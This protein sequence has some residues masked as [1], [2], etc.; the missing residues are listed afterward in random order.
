MRRASRRILL[1]FCVTHSFEMTFMECDGQP[2]GKNIGLAPRRVRMS[3]G[4]ARNAVITK[5]FYVRG[6]AIRRIRDSRNGLFAASL[7][8]KFVVSQ[9]FGGS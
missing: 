1:A 2:I 4:Y 6:D 7:A 8:M 5:T 3:P 9:A